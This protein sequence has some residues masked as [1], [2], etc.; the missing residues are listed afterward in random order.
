[1]LVNGDSFLAPGIFLM[2][3]PVDR[4]SEFASSLFG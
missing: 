4:A 3:A 2:N 1:L